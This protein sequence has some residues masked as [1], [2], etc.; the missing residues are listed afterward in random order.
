MTVNL[1]DTFDRVVVLNLAR[2]ADRWERFQA[3]LGDWPFKP[4][5]RFEAVDGNAVSIPAGWTQGPG[6]WGCQLSHRQ[7][8]D[9]AIADDLQTLLVL[10]DDACPVESFSELA[11]VFLND[12]PP[13]WDGLML[14][15]VHLLKPQFIRP[16]VVRCGLANRT[17]AFAVRGR[18]MRVLSQFWRVN[19]TDHCDIV[20][21]SL[22]PHFKV[23]S[24]DPLLIGQDSGFSDVSG[25][26]EPLRFLATEHRARIS[27]RRHPV[28]NNAPV[29]AFRSTVVPD[30]LHLNRFN[31]GGNAE[32]PNLS[33]RQPDQRRAG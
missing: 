20:L 15:A 4:P 1:T 22:M 16:G 31:P 21:A 12:V 19:T 6:A 27:A 5:Q 18:F 25:R 30:N 3:A 17:H 2:R 7:V 10:E 8:L 26:E 13:D 29:G 11:A 23:Y 28:R 14:G 32:D 24:P 9:Q 33:Q